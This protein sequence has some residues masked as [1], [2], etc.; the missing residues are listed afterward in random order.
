MSLCENKSVTASSWLKAAALGLCA[1]LG[2]SAPALANSKSLSVDYAEQILNIYRAHNGED[3]LPDVADR[4]QGGGI[5]Q[6]QF[7]VLPEVESGLLIDSNVRATPRG[8]SDDGAC[9]RRR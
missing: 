8:G 3:S 4:A 2:L 1:V 6:G 5:R 9:R 7:W